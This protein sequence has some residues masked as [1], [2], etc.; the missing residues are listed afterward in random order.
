MKLRV[1][2]NRLV[3]KMDPE[4]EVKVGSIILSGASADEERKVR[5][6]TVLSSNIEG[7]SAGEQIMYSRMFGTVIKDMII[8]DEKDGFVVVEEE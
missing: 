7:V 3:A 8:L 1:V 5:R 2:G 4:E 6:A